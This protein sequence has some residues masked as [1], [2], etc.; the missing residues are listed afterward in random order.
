MFCSKCGAAVNGKFCS[1]CGQRIR[2][3]LEEYHLAERR[4]KKEFENRC[5]K[6]GNA[7]ELHL[8]NLASACWLASSMKYD[9]SRGLLIGDYVPQSVYDN[10]QVVRDHAEKLYQAL[11]NF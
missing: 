2:S 3:S 10:L 8:M 11:I 1:C 7:R 4:M 9:R 6:N 5:C